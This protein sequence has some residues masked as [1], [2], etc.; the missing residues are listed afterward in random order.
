MARFARLTSIDAVRELAVALRIFGEEAL[1]A[2]D[3]LDINVQRATDWIEQD[4]KNFWNHEV[5]RGTERLSEARVELEKAKTYRK[6]DDFTPAC[7]EER[8]LVDRMKSRLQT[9]EEK[10]RVLPHWEQKIR[11]A[12][13]ELSGRQTQLATWLREDLPSAISVLEQMMRSL[14]RY[15]AATGGPAPQAAPQETGTMKEIEAE[16]TEGAEAEEETEEADT[17]HRTPNTENQ[18]SQESDQ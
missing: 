9:A 13:R 1:G 7:R 5:R 3:E 8:V 16:E 14:E 2:L 17:E 10:H 15:A 11:H 18:N 4:R 12:I 6:M